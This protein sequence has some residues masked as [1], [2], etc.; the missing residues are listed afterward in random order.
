MSPFL[1]DVGGLGLEISRGFWTAEELGMS[2]EFGVEGNTVSGDDRLSG[3][4]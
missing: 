4:R 1:G 2:S 3:L